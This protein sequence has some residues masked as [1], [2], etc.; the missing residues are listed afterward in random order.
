[1]EDSTRSS[2]ILL[3]GDDTAKPL[4]RLYRQLIR[5]GRANNFQVVLSTFSMAVTPFSPREATE[6]YSM[7]VSRGDGIAARMAAHNRIVEKIAAEQHVPL[8][9][10]TPDLN[11]KWDDDLFLDPFHLTQKGSDHLAE[12]MFAGLIP[13]FRGDE[14]LRCSQRSR[15]TAHPADR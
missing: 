6:F 3:G 9:D 12:T 5:L 8:I 10:T 13:I 2:G 1:M 11:G 4:R 15:N 14:T 7:T